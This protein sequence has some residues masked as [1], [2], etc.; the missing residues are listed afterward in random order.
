MSEVLALLSTI[1]DPRDQG[2]ILYPLPTLLFIAIC[3][4]FSGAES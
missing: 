3:A 4:I 1:E 2:K